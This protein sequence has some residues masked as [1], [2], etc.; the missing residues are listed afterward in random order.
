M[1]RNAL[2]VT[3]FVVGAMAGTAGAAEAPAGSAKPIRLFNGK[4]LD[5]WYVYT[6]QTKHENP[7]VF[8]VVDGML[9]IPGG[10]D[11]VAYFG[12]LITKN[13]FA[14]YHLVVEYKFGK[15][16]YGSRKDKARDSGILL[17]C[18]GPDGPGPWPTS[19]ECQIIEGGTGDFIMVG[20]K[21]NAGN[22]IKHSVTVEAEKRGGQYY[23]KPGG[24]LVTV[25]GVRI[26]WYDRDP[27]WK[28]VADFRGA[29]DVESRLGEWTRVECICKGDSITN[30]VNGKVV[31]RGTG[32]VLHKGKILI[33]TEGAEMWVRKVE[34]TRLGQQ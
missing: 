19:I 1:Q 10:K 18:V 17:H 16:T 6:V 9:K 8:T 33:Q 12:G 34:L 11:D 23:Y 28:D 13:E 30:I 24:P 25:G 20:G 29:K 27:A 32:F 26:N 21:D 3:W 5:G 2:V 4:D 22:A 15:P 7:G 31:N 14:N